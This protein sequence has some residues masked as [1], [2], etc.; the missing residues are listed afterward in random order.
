MRAALSAALVAAL[1]VISVPAAG[2][3]LRYPAKGIPRLPDG[4]ANLSAP[5]PRTADGKPDLSGIWQANGPKYLI[6]I[7]ADL[8][9]GDVPFRP[10]AETLFKERGTLTHAH[11]E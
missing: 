11:E 4:K 2:Q 9:P 10:A 6:N 5:A 7:A 1:S 3:W 8:K